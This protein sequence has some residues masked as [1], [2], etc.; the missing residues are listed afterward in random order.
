MCGVEVRSSAARERRLPIDGGYRLI[1]QIADMGH[2]LLV[3]AGGD[4]LDGSKGVKDG[5]SF[6]F[7]SHLEDVYP[8]GFLPVSTGNSRT[9][10]LAVLYRNTE[11]FRTCVIYPV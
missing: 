10:K 4:P 7:V 3:F 5:N 9:Q 11:L 8:S 2:L 1:D 6:G